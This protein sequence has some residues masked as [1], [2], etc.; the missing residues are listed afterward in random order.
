MVNLDLLVHAEGVSVKCEERGEG[1]VRV[2]MGIS[3]TLSDRATNRQTMQGYKL[4][5]SPVL[6]CGGEEE[7]RVQ[8]MSLGGRSRSTFVHLDL[9]GLSG[10]KQA[11]RHGRST[12]YPASSSGTCLVGLFL[13]V[14]SSYK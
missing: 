3:T 11:K 8:V 12:R 1:W 6:L 10:F 5:R 9:R 14:P 4:T 2:V 7:V 13:L